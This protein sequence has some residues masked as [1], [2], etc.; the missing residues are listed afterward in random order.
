MLWC[1]SESICDYEF[2]IYVNPKLKHTIAPS[3]DTYAL[4]SNQITLS[5][6][7]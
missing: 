7:D 6:S 4:A 2:K 3:D 5:P 1:D